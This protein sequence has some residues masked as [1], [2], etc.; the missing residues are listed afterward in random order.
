LGLGFLNDHQQYGVDDHPLKAMEAMG[1]GSFCI[2]DLGKL[3]H[4]AGL[5]CCDGGEYLEGAGGGKSCWMWEETEFLV[6]K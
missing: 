3:P 6:E 4:L 1:I 5:C 2:S